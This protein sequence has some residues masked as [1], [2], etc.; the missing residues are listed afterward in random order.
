MRDIDYWALGGNQTRNT[1]FTAPHTAHYPGTPQGRRPDQCGAHGCTLVQVDEDRK[2]RTTLIP[3]DLL[4]WHAERVVVEPS[5]S[6]ENLETRL[7]DR[8]EKLRE[9]MPGTDLLISWTIVGSG[10]LA[11][12]LRRGKLASE[13][14]GVL[15]NEFGAGS[16]VAWSASM[17]ME[18]A[19]ELP[20]EWFEQNT[21]CGDFLRELRQEQ[22]APERPL[23][24]TDYLP[25]E[26]AKKEASEA[27]A[28][29]D[30]SARDGTARADGG[31][32]RR[33]RAGDRAPGSR[34]AR[35]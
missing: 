24:L 22:L 30:R 13:L 28:E 25:K 27:G 14:L 21:I 11:T 7:H 23:V 10:P 1:L 2:L 33:E 8:V 6:R 26:L 16:P 5:T 4:R 35:C 9:S 12:Q 31:D 18:P 19:V 32:F 34:H 17:E 20:A 3:C 15:Q 29:D